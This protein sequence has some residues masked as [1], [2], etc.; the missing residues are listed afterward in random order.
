M[1]ARARTCFNQEHGGLRLCA[2]GYTEYSDYNKINYL[3]SQNRLLAVSTLGNG[4]IQFMVPQ[5]NYNEIMLTNIE[6]V[7]DNLKNVGG[8]VLLE[9]RFEID[10]AL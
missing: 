8:N 5:Y 2:P 6:T 4:K 1:L 9:D 3:D 7:L 10:V